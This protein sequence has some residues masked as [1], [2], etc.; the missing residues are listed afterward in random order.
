MIKQSS[1][2]GSGWQI[3]DTS[4]NIFNVMN[5]RLQAHSPAEE[6]TYTTSDFLSNGF[7]LRDGDPS[8]NSNG[9]TY[10]YAAFAEAPFK[11]ARAR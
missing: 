3:H 9:A 4:R 6:S 5:N 10:I 1:S 11:Y 2:S 8:W 7:K